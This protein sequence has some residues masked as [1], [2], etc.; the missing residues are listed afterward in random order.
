M[1]V[2]PPPTGDQ[3]RRAPDKRGA[4]P[5]RGE[6]TPEREER[7]LRGPTRRET[8]AAPPPITR[9]IT[10]SEGITVKELSE[11]LDIKSSM[12]IKKLVDRNIFATINQTLD[13]KL[14]NELARDFGASVNTISFEQEAMQDVQEAEVEADRVKR[15]PVVTIMGHV[16]HGKTSLLDAIRVANVAEKEAG[17]ITHHIGA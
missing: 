6:R 14:A 10:I 11:K 1:G 5:V 2:E 12:V 9:E 17:A 7:V 4:R 8:P 16:D 13:S 3:Q 15:A